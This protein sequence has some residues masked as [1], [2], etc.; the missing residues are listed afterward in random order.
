MDNIS[1]AQK[2]TESKD[3]LFGYRDPKEWTNDIAKTI[4][5]KVGYTMSNDKKKVLSSALN[6]RITNVYDE[7]FPG[8]IFNDINGIYE[9]LYTNGD[10]IFIQISNEPSHVLMRTTGRVGYSCEHMDND[11]W[12]GPFHDIAL[13]NPTAYFTDERGTWLGRLNIRWALTEEGKVVVGIDPNIYPMHQMYRHRDDTQLKE[14][15]Y[16]ILKDYLQYNDAKTP[17]LYKGHSDTTSRYPDVSLPFIGY[18]KLMAKLKPVYEP[19]SYYYR[20]YLYDDWY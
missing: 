3:P 12:L 15:I 11:A 17:Y 1:Y 18:D 2:I 10:K 8:L 4:R 9:V 6:Y 13:L 5:E 16:Y 20:D 14:G 7:D 19:P